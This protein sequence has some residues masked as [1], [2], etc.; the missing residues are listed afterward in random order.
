MSL[1]LTVAPSHPTIVVGHSNEVVATGPGIGVDQEFRHVQ[2]SGNK[3]EKAIIA[4][5]QR[6]V[7][8]MKVETCSMYSVVNQD[9]T[10]HF[11]LPFS[12]IYHT[13]MFQT[14]IKIWLI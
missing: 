4:H 14:N 12:H 8:V 11:F 2:I 10:L 5:V 6:G 1:S 9:Q 7:F 13:D 3:H